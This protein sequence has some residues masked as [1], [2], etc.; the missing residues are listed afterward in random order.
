[1][2]FVK[3]EA[4]KLIDIN[5]EELYQNVEIKSYKNKYTI[6][7]P[8]LGE[9]QILNLGVAINT[10]EVLCEQENITLNKNVIEKSLAR[11]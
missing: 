2:Y 8:L 5:Y 11:C 1:M 10:I 6:K 7:L 4:G 9:H 3:K